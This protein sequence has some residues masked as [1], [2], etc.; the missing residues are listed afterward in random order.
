[1]SPELMLS[2]LPVKAPQGRRMESVSPS[3]TV[4]GSSRLLY[5]GHVLARD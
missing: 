4:C 5:R 3:L 2:S 1:M